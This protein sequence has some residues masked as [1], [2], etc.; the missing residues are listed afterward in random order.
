M[1]QYRKED[2]RKENIAYFH[3][4]LSSVL[5]ASTPWANWLS[6]FIH[7]YNIKINMDGYEWHWIRV[8]CPVSCF[9]MPISHS[10]ICSFACSFFSFFLKRYFWLHAYPTNGSQHAQSFLEID[11]SH[12]WYDLERGGDPPPHP[13]TKKG[14]IN[15]R[16][17]SKENLSNILLIQR[18]ISKFCQHNT[19]LFCDSSTLS[20]KI[21]SFTNLGG[22]TTAIFAHMDPP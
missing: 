21:F 12:V 19:V 4:L 10:L 6:R 3:F 2:Y 13:I 18:S 8:C 20:S 7:Q 17:T 22:L 1:E 5:S 15:C 14:Q 16:P 11:L 9:Q